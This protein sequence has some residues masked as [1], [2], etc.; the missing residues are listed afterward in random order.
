MS[1]GTGG[2]AEVLYEF[3]ANTVVRRGDKPMVPGDPIA[4]ALPDAM[5][6]QLDGQA[7]APQGQQ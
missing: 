2:P 4:M 3:F 6:A 7:G 1:E 5:R